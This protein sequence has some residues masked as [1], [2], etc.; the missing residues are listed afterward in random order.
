MYSFFLVDWTFY[1][2]TMSLSLI[3]F[4]VLKSVLSNINI[5]THAFFIF[6]TVC[7]AYSFPSFYFQPIYIIDCAVSFLLAVYNWVI[8][9]ICSENLCLLIVVFGPFTCKVI[10]ML[11][12]KSVVLLFVFYL[13]PL[14]L[15]SMFIFSYSVSY[16]KILVVFHL[17]LFILFLIVS[18]CKV[19]RVVAMGITIYILITIS[20][21]HHLNTS[22][23]VLIPYYHLGPLKFPTF[24]YHC[25]EYQMV[26]IFV[27]IIKYDL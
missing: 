4:F 1:H 21:H 14:V 8:F 26:I 22:N 25:L 24:K 13:F 15:I 20:W 6:M 3:I 17:D 12:L 19:F 2:S 10:N 7:K 18:L 16:L 27:S 23:E 11:L 5:D 9:W